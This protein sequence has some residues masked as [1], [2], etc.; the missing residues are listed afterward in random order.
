MGCWP[1]SSARL[2]GGGTRDA[3]LA[4]TNGRGRGRALGFELRHGRVAL[5][6]R[7]ASS[8]RLG[9]QGRQGRQGVAPF[10]Q[11]RDVVARQMSELH[12][13]AMSSEL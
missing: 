4:N 9:R 6:V 11:A 3:M 7:V 5:V 1:W 8:C 13:A 10:L 2:C 12:P